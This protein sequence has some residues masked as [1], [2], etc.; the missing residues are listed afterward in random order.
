MAYLGVPQSKLE[1]LTTNIQVVELSASF[2]GSAVTFNMQDNRGAAVYAVHDRALMVVL[3]GVVQKPGVDYTTNGTTITFTTAPVSNLTIAI[4]KLYGTQRISTVNDGVISPSKLTTGGPNWNSSGNVTISGDLNVT[5]SFNSGANGLFWEDNE[6]AKFGS[7]NDLQIY[8]NGTDSYISDTATG[9]LVLTG[10]RVIVK[11]AA[12]N[13]RMIDAIEGGAVK[14]LHN[15]SEK[16]ETTATGITVTGNI[17]GTGNFTLT[18][19]STGSVA[20]PEIDLFRNSTSPSDADYIGQIKFTGKQDGGGTVNYA[21]ITGKILDASNGTEDGILEFMLRKAG[22]N[23]IAARFRSDSLQL[24]NGTSLTVN[25]NISTDANINLDDSTSSSVGRLNIGAGDDLQIYHDPGSS[26]YISCENAGSSLHLRAKFLFQLRTGTNNSLAMH[27]LGGGQVEIWHQGT[28]AGKKIETTAA[29]AKVTGALEVTQEYPTIKP[30]LDLNF[31]A[32]KTLDRRIT[33]TRD[34]FATF[35]DDTGIVRYA[36]HNVPRFDHNPT[37]GESLGL[38]IEESR[39]NLVEYGDFTTGWTEWGGTA[40]STTE[41]AAPDGTFTAKKIR[42]KG[43]VSTAG[44]YDSINYLSNTSYT[45]TM[46]LKAGTI[47]IAGLTVNSGGKWAG[48]NYPYI[49][50][51]LSTGAVTASGG[52]SA[53][54]TAYPNG[55]YRLEATGT[56]AGNSSV[57]A[58]WVHSQT[59]SSMVGNTTGY[60]YVWGPQAEAGGFG[61]SY[62]RTTGTTVTRGAEK[63]KIT[64]TNFTDFHNATEGTLYGE[65][66]STSETA[67]Y[68]VMLS[69]GTDNNRT[70]INSN[71]DTYQAVVKYNN[72]TNQAVIDAG[73]PIANANNKTALA[74]KKD[75]FALSLNGGTVATDTSGDV[76]VNNMMTIGSRHGN[77]SF[78]NTTINGI[79]YYNK[80]LPNAQLQGL[81]QQ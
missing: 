76:S 11:N 81:T 79:K 42:S 63:A 31:A 5:G 69:D 70:I 41:T 73:T 14:L 60:Y 38:L 54:A 66:K 8:H 65:Y 50:V 43:D 16:L 12:D 18:S 48:S 7:D 6:R 39:T 17:E 29:G 28:G 30:V 25:G 13:A 2:D 33:F 51:N 56:Y 64:G 72:G 67:P 10:S 1:N 77:D 80:R 23:N 22:S 32:T 75:D 53:K 9:S 21:K 3:G 40:T 68:I 47:T 57:D 49:T 37:T 27:A 58:I 24:L 61:T 71:Y 46:W 62:I 45:H 55:W 44:I 74:F 4:R 78:A 59:G 15:N 26:T 35:T 36:S 52:V 19:T 20:A 34:S